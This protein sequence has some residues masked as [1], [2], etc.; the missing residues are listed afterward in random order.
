M[1]YERTYS[2]WLNGKVNW[3]PNPKEGDEFQYACALGAGWVTFIYF[4]G[5]WQY[6]STE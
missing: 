2:G 4:M 3:P 1:S 5:T 6:H